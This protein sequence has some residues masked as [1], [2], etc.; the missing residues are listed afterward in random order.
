ML[1]GAGYLADSKYLERRGL[2]YGR[3]VLELGGVDV[4]NN[5]KTFGV[6]SNRRVRN[7]LLQFPCE[8]FSDPDP[9]P[10]GRFHRHCPLRCSER[11]EQRQLAQIEIHTSE[12][13]LAP[14]ADLF[15]FT[16][17]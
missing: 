13:R 2:E 10:A 12:K 15:L 4:A 16:N 11:Q 14:P 7:A 5:S 3:S 1:D 8:H 9:D 6:S 17:L